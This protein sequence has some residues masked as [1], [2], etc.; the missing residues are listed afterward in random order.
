MKNIL[1][2]GGAGFIGSNFARYILE[3]EPQA[4]LIN[5]DA[6]TYAGNRNNLLDM[7]GRDGYIFIQGDICD[8]ELTDHLLEIY[9]IDTI[10]NFAAETHV[11]RSI[12]D[13]VPFIETNIRGTVNLLESAKKAWLHKRLVPVET[14]RF[15]HIS[16]DEVYGS[17]GP[18]SRPFTENSPYS[19]NSPYAASKAASDHFARAYFNTYKIPVTITNCSNNYGPFQ[20]PEKLIPLIISNALAGK[21]LPIYGDGKQI[22]DWLYVTD[23]CEAIL[24]TLKYGVAGETYNIGGNNQITNLELV[25]TICDMLDEYIPGSKLVPHRKLIRFT[26]DR[27]GH[28]RRYGVDT[29]KIHDKFGW[30]PNHSLNDGLRKTITWYIENRDWVHHQKTE[31]PFN[32]DD[33]EFF[34]R[35]GPG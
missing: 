28:D 29:T 31:T 35:P 27:P 30:K 14:A 2:T 8:R 6:L 19:P 15:H 5:L 33:G 24:L 21:E 16:T 32:W 34:R 3:K 17:L 4:R 25:S 11:D 13:P 9:S 1:V 23:H 18:Q 26:A 7:Q 20:H 10:I 22:R 12:I